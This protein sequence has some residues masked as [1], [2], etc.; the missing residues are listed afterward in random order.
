MGD[1]MNENNSQII[2][3]LAIYNK[4]LIVDFNTGEYRQWKLPPDEKGRPASKL[5]ADYW[6]WFIESGLLNPNDIES[7]TEF[8]RKP[9]EIGHCCYKRLVRGE[10]RQMIMEIVANDDGQTHALYVRDITS[11][12]ARESDK[13]KSYDEMTGLLNNYA[14]ERDIANYNGPSVGAIYVDLNGLKYFNDNFSHEE[15]DKKIMALANLLKSMFPD[16]NIYRVHG[17][18]FVIIAFNPNIM[19]FIQR[20]VCFNRWQW[21]EPEIPLAAVGFSVDNTGV[22]ISKVVKAAEAEMFKDKEEF[23]KKFPKYKRS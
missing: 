16:Y 23:H 18:E 11:I 13:L 10:W 22:D 4:I 12:Y 14:Y 21:N 2:D 17:D 1:I 3:L 6:N 15:G 5:I 20:C 8:T 9:L 7:F 19:N